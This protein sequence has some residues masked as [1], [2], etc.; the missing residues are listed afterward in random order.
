M[1]YFTV[2]DLEGF[3]GIY[4]YFGVVKLRNTKDYWN[5][6]HRSHKSIENFVNP[7]LQKPSVISTDPSNIQNYLDSRMRAA[8]QS[9]VY[10]KQSR[11][12]INQNMTRI[13]SYE[14]YKHLRRYFRFGPTG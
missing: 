2:S 14:K 13:M 10:R 1:N 5:L 7:E 4:L 6:G 9:T 3:I 11:S 12:C 8:K